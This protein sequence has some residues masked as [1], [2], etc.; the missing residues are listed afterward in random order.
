MMTNKYSI[1]KKN[2]VEEAARV[3][4]IVYHLATRT[5]FFGQTYKGKM[6]T[7]LQERMPKFFATLIF[8]HYIMLLHAPKVNF[9]FFL[10][11]F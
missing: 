1:E 7:V 4:M 11:W 6:V 10:L 5:N 8:R 9:V 2:F 3:G